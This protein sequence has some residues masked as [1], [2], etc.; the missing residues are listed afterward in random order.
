MR[1]D[2]WSFAL[3]FLGHMIKWPPAV[4]HI[5][6]LIQRKGTAVSQTAAGLVDLHRQVLRWADN[7]PFKS[8]LRR[9]HS[10]RMNLTTGL[11]PSSK[12]VGLIA[13]GVAEGESLQ[14]GPSGTQYTLVPELP[15]SAAFQ[16]YEKVLKEGELAALVWP[17]TATECAA[18]ANG[19]LRAAQNIRS[20]SVDGFGL[21]GGVSATHQYLVKHLTRAFLFGVVESGI[22]PAAF[23]SMPMSTLMAWLPDQGQHLQV[24]SDWSVARVQKAFGLHPLWV[25]CWTCLSAAMPESDMTKCLLHTDDALLKPVQDFEDEMARL[26][27]TGDVS[28]PP[29]PPGPRIIAQSLPELPRKG[30]R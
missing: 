1:V 27:G 11:I 24:I 4:R 30:R 20:F 13:Q 3:L 14:L 29:F 2:G 26:A 10:A 8:M 18:F 25:S 28:D 9:M 21:V 19:V 23:D 22:A 5:L 6:E 17:T 7:K 15:E 16:I 12:D